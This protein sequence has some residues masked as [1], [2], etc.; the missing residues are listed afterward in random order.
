M[1]NKKKTNFFKKIFGKKSTCCSLEFEE[2]NAED[3]K[4]SAKSKEK[5]ETNCCCPQEDSNKQNS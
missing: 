4:T 2:I 1:E 3:N 5:T